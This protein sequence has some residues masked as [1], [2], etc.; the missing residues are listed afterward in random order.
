MVQNILKVF[1][2]LVLF[3]APVFTVTA[4]KIAHWFR[5]E[6]KESKSLERLDLPTLEVL[7]GFIMGCHLIHLKEVPIEEIYFHE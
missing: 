6:A 2:S 7:N 1:T 3:L 4:K 5:L